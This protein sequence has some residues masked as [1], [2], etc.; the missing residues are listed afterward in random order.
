[1]EVSLVSKN[2]RATYPSKKGEVEELE[3]AILPDCIDEKTGIV[4]ELTPYIPGEIIIEEASVIESPTIGETPETVLIDLIEGI[5]KLNDLEHVLSWFD[6]KENNINQNIIDVTKKKLFDLLKNTVDELNDLKTIKTLAEKLNALNEYTQIAKAPILKIISNYRTTPEE[7]L[8]VTKEAINLGVIDE[9]Q[10]LKIC[11]SLANKSYVSPQIKLSILQLII[12]ESLVKNIINN[13]K[14]LV[15]LFA[16]AIGNS[17]YSLQLLND[18]DFKSNLVEY[19]YASKNKRGSA[20]KLVENIIFVFTKDLFGGIEHKKTPIETAVINSILE[21]K[22]KN[23]KGLVESAVE[24]LSYKSRIDKSFNKFLPTSNLQRLIQNHTLLEVKNILDKTLE[25]SSVKNNDVAK[26]YLT[27]TTATEED[28][29]LAQVLHDRLKLSDD[30]Y[31]I[32]AN[33]INFLSK[34]GTEPDKRREAYNFIKSLQYLAKDRETHC[35]DGI[36]RVLSDALLVNGDAVYGL[37]VEPRVAIELEKNGFKVL[38]LSIKELN[39][40][41]LEEPDGIP[42]QI[43]IIAE[44]EII[45]NGEKKVQIYH[46]EVKANDKAFTK[47]NKEKDLPQSIA[48][49]KIAIEHGAEHVIVIEKIDDTRDIEINLECLRDYTPDKGVIAKY[50]SHPAIWDRYGNV[51]FERNCLANNTRADLRLKS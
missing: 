26:Q 1:M 5:T 13:N 19:L 17:E 25:L 12:N 31:E 27:Y 22:E 48:L 7:L 41:K 36:D 8:Q 37:Y 33:V 42:R 21:G 4:L 43:D 15:K 24:L 40:K 14:G 29:Q 30:N 16:K 45:I 39:N 20:E 50:N 44:K 11:E 47:A 28:K 46:I 51:Q 6:D 18:K 23:D 34:H 38:Q 2:L 35:I 9:V 49:E 3:V 32:R 10:I